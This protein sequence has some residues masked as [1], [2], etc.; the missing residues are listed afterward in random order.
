VELSA[1]D[2]LTTTRAVR[3][4]LDL[5]RAVP[6]TVLEECLEIA[7]QAPNP[8]NRQDQRF[9]PVSDPA[10]KAALAEIYRRGRAAV[11][12]RWADA[13]R[14][15][16]GSPTDARSDRQRRPTEYLSERLHEVPWILIPCM[17]G[18][19]AGEAPH[20]P[21]EVARERAAAIYGGAAPAV[22]SFMLAARLRGI[23]TA[24]TT[25]H[26][27]HVE[28]AAALLGIP[29]ESHVQVALVPIACYLGASFRRG[30]RRSASELIRWER[31]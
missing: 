3:R 29:Y 6:R 14:G 9:V 26:L 7:V 11:L 25:A 28:A 16:E 20:P 24:W 5:V 19:L 22:W 31:W 12:R 8:G 23:G 10:T 13:A 1:E 4:R 27:Q 30:P 15:A 2:L 21:G 18:R 17:A